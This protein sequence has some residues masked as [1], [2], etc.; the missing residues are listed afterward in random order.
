MQDYISSWE[1]LSRMQVAK[2]TDPKERFLAYGRDLRLLTTLS[3]NLV[4]FSRWEAR[5]DPE[6]PDRYRI[7]ISEAS[8]YPESLAW[9]T[10]GLVNRMSTQHG[11]PNLWRWERVRPDLIVF[12]MTRSL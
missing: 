4:N 3:A 6:W 9:Q 8:D 1:Y 12:R 7:E 2:S 10:D 5:P 11:E